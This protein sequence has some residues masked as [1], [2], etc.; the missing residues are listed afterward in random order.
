MRLPSVPEQK[1][2]PTPGFQGAPGLQVPGPPVFQ[3]GGGLLLPSLTPGPISFRPPPPPPNTVSQ[4][5]LQLSGAISFQSQGPGLQAPNFQSRFGPLPGSPLPVSSTPLPSL[6]RP[7]SIPTAVQPL[8][9]PT[10]QP[11]TPANPS[12]LSQTALLREGDA[13]FKGWKEALLNGISSEPFRQAPDDQKAA[14]LHYML[15]QTLLTR[16]RFNQ[17][18]IELWPVPNE[19]I[20]QI[21]SDPTKLTYSAPSRIISRDNPQFAVWEQSLAAMLASTEFIDT[22]DEGRLVMLM[23]HKALTSLSREEFNALLAKLW[24]H[25]LYGQT[26][27]PMIAKDL[28][29]LIWIRTVIKAED[30]P[31]LNSA[32]IG[33]L[34]APGPFRP[35]IVDY[36]ELA[37]GIGEIRQYL[38]RILE[39]ERV[40]HPSVNEISAELND[41]I[42]NITAL[43]DRWRKARYVSRNEFVPMIKYWRSEAL[44]ILEQRKKLGRRCRNAQDPLSM[45]D[46]NEIPENEFIKMQSG[47]CWNIN[48]LLDYVQDTTNGRNDA[49]R[50]ENYG[51]P[52]LWH[53][54]QELNAILARD[55]ARARDFRAWLDA[56]DI[57]HLAPRISK[58]TLDVMY[59]IAQIL[60]SRGDTWLKLAQG[61]LGPWAAEQFMKYTGG[62]F[63]R[64]NQI[65]PYVVDGKL[66]GETGIVLTLKEQI[67]DRLVKTRMATEK[68]ESREAIRN[69]ILLDPDQTWELEL[70]ANI[71]PLRGNIRRQVKVAMKREAINNFWAYYNTLSDDEKI[72]L[73]TVEPSFADELRTC[74]EGNR[75]VYA[76][77]G[78]LNGV[79]QRVAASKRLRYNII[80][81]SEPP[82]R[83]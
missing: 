16:P 29:K 48:S 31:E 50:L 67:V 79:V 19:S 49:T 3:A 38:E 52:Q 61:I 18:L 23:N 41:L 9:K 76:W 42:G 10:V 27:I 11:V 2:N 68:V 5:G 39:E 43:M 80:D 33:E 26:H 83:A 64:L 45:E 59:V 70:P 32:F 17:L 14:V 63:D 12:P 72:A 54:N 44:R 24:P 65:P 60:V 21:I 15:G 7:A 22:P 74:Y 35:E 8:S 58:E 1:P 56:R 47:Y 73:D 66:S 20:P 13:K 53:D 6:P 4:P 30:P 25:S 37:N 57:A 46:V 40:Y 55:Q 81:T 51:S 28:K 69:S 36:R 34:L 77:A 75:C 82:E 71:V 62:N 78:L